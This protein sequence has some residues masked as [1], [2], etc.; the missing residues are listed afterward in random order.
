MILTQICL[1]FISHPRSA[2]EDFA[3]V[4][5]T[6][7][8][9]VKILSGGLPRKNKTNVNPLGL[10]ALG[11]LYLWFLVFAALSSLYSSSS[12]AVSVPAAACTR[13]AASQDL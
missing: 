5:A 8:T 4:P 1:T 9:A 3:V 6:T 13:F 11:H 2:A 7:D 12:A 10:M